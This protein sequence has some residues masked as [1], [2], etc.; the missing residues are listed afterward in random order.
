MELLFKRILT[1]LIELTGISRNLV[2]VNIKSCIVGQNYS[3]VKKRLSKY[4]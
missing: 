3:R 4:G 2:E 1:I